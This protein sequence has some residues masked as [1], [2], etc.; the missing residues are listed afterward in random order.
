MKS[1]VCP[2]CNV[3][4]PLVEFHRDC[5]KEDGRTTVC[6]ACRCET[7]KTRW[8]QYKAKYQARRQAYYQAH[9]KE[10]VNRGRRWKKANP[11]SAR[12][13]RLW[14]QYRIRLTDYNALLLK[15]GG[16]C[17]ICGDPPDLAYRGLAVDHDHTCC[18]GEK[19]CG[20]CIRGLLCTS[21]NLGISYFREHPQLLASAMEYLAEGETAYLERLDEI[22][23]Q[24]G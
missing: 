14:T 15:Q 12:N 13:I 22:G 16:G 9:K 11:E 5:T 3:D 6:A 4:K 1:K 24:C 20:K 10:W 18:P 2:K 7:A 21:C 17:A 19:S 23:Q 8:P